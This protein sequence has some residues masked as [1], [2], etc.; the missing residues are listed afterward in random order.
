MVL[1]EADAKSSLEGIL[2]NLRLHGFLD[3]G[4][5][6]PALLLFWITWCLI[7]ATSPHGTESALWEGEAEGE[8]C[9]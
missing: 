1:V 6:I 5:S 9:E 4:V 7:P 2:C 8:F 3:C